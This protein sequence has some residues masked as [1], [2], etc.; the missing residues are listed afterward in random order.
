MD[1][2]ADVSGTGGAIDAEQTGPGTPKSENLVTVPH[3]VLTDD[4]ARF[5]GH[6]GGVLWFTGLS[7]AGKS[8]LAVELERLLFS[9]GYQV[10]LLDGDNVR[11]GLNAD[12][13]F[14]PQHRSENIRRVGEVA[15]L[16]ADAGLVVISAFISP[17]RAD[18]ERARAAHPGSFFEIFINAPLHVCEARDAKGLYRRARAGVIRDF[19]GVS[20][21]YERP[22]VPDLEIPTAEWPVERCLSELAR[23][24]EARLSMPPA[25]PEIQAAALG[26]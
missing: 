22:L 23:F 15:G 10:Y 12:L 17:Y 9:R 8:T 25:A 16:F 5:N 2:R 4:R 26:R 18:R 7:G 21:P 20:A 13:G 14:S 3:R 24:I 19:T 1:A 6:R 11:Q